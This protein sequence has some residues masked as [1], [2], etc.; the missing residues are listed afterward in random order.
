MVDRARLEVPMSTQ[1]SGR[2]VHLIGVTKRF[3]DTVAVDDIDLTIEPGEF[4]SLLGPSGCGKT[5]TLR[6]VAGFEFPDLGDVRIDDR[7]VVDVPPHRREVTMVF[8]DYAL[9]PHR[10]VR[11]NV[12]FGLRM[13]KIAKEEIARRVDGML[14]LLHLTDLRDRKPDQLSGGQ[15]QR[16]ALGRALVPETGV[17]LFD[18]PLGALDLKL[19]KR[20]Q[21]ELKQ[22]HRELGGTFIYVTHDQ[23]EAI[24]MSDRIA[25]MDQGKVLQ[26]ASA[27]DVYRQPK[28]RFVAEFIGEANVLE[29]VVEADGVRCGPLLV[30]VD[31]SDLT[32]GQAAVLIVRPERVRV[33][34]AANGAGT[35]FE[36]AVRDVVFTGPTLR[37]LGTVAGMELQVTTSQEMSMTPG[38]NETLTVGWDP[39]DA[40]VLGNEEVS[41]GGVPWV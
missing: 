39:V 6:M 14:E 34:E 13:R 32:V 4:V 38:T 28:T 27:V 26:F 9:F 2:A 8:Q 37:I 36:L 19:R 35:T 12:A 11:Q 21:L 18:E 7:S 22:I 10:T 15:R 1:M 30:K 17:I 23:E 41:E 29:G 16:V 31:V 5:T 33:G 24:T 40:L 3:G 25:V 20:M